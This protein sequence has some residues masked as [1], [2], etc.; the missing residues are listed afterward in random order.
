MF[1]LKRNIYTNKINKILKGL[2]SEIHISKS[3]STVLYDKYL[4]LQTSKQKTN[5]INI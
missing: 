4:Y 1:D 5:K 2:T 3:H